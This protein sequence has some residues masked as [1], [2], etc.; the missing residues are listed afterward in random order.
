M[1]ELRLT[2]LFK[3]LEIRVRGFLI[4]LS[5]Q[6]LIRAQALAAWQVSAYVRFK[7]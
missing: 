5:C 1:I 3:L 7:M 4:L 6:T 2:D